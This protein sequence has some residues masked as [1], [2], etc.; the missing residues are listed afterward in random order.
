[1]R[2]LWRGTALLSLLAAGPL[3]LGLGLAGCGEKITIPEPEGLY[4]GSPYRVDEEFEDTAAPSQIVIANQALFVIAGNQV[5]K[6]DQSYGSISV[7][8]QTAEPA[9]LCTDREQDWLF[10]YDAAGSSVSWFST[11]NGELLGE[12]FVP[13]VQSCNSMV[14]CAVGVDQV[15]GASTYLYLSDPDSAVVHRYA[16]D[17]LNG[18]Y[19][20]GILTRAGGDAARF[21]HQP[22][23]LA[24]D[25]AD[26]LLV[27]DADTLRNWII[28]FV[29]EPD[30]LDVTPDEEDQDPL[31]GRAALWGNQSGCLNHPAG[32]YVLGNAEE[33][34]GGDWIPGTSSESG[35][36]NAPTGMAVDGSGRIFVADTGNDRIQI[37]DADGNYLLQFGNPDLTPR[38]IGIGVIDKIIDPA[39]NQVNYGAYVY[40]LL[41]GQTRVV[42]FISNE[43]ANEE[44]LPPPPDDLR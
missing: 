23:G 37:F 17:E 16:F 34:G 27:S 26:S 1:M 6:R 21:V 15:P 36:F 39:N 5:V 38:P 22:A 24:R 18:L 13:E 44:N 40:V 10:V 28:R 32:D 8:S 12:T 41:E 43:Q 3:L 35:E 31:R 2:N 11:T 30:P 4:S 7:N 14:T 42:K 9:A 29:A 19:P 25:S 20:H 33:C